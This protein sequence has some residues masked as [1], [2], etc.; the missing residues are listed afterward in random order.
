MTNRY[1]NYPK[2]MF[3]CIITDE[4]HHYMAP[5]YIKPLEYF[6]PKLLTGWTATPKRLDGLSL[7]NIFDKMV[8]DYGIEKGIEEGWL[9]KI[10]A[11]RIQTMVDLTKVKKVAGDF[12]QRELSI[13]VDT[14]ERNSLIAQKLHK[15]WKGEP[16]MAFC[17]D[18][19]HAYNLRDILR[20]HGFTAEAVTSD[21]TRCPN[22]SEI[23]QSFKNK[24]FNVLVN[25]NIATEG[26]DFDDV[27]LI[28]M[29]RPTQSE[30]LY[31]QMI[32]RGTRL[33]SAEFREK[34]GHDHCTV[35]DFVD[36]T[37]RH[38]LVNCYELER[39]KP[40]EERI[41]I[42]DKDREIIMEEKEKR[43]MKLLTFYGDDRKIDLLKLPDIFIS[44][45]PAMMD[46]ATPKQ[47]AFMQSLGVWQE[48]VDYT[49]RDASE[50]IG[51]QPVNHWKLKK[52]ADLGY[53][54][55]AGATISQYQQVMK[56]QEEKEPREDKYKLSSPDIS[57]IVKELK[58]R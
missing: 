28:A 5:S 35:L 39:D 50:L 33:K 31:I 40:V 47:I 45:S 13:A 24:K 19:D 53:D 43:R 52:L 54:V 14:R 16:I 55:I 8:F 3:D 7:G 25:V 36:V 23:V 27:G 21:T 41:F 18:I 6:E 4:A 51:S 58:V 42:S 49:K 20:E 12:N 9:A 1:T 57:K 34:Y 30:S 44:K 32:G 22:R 17:V 56:A 15:Y 10:D 46:A 37:A 11:Y 2:D 48:G 38:S 29:T 26:F